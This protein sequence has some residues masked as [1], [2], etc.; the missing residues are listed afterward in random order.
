[1]EFVALDQTWSGPVHGGFRARHRFMDLTAP[2]PRAVLNET[3]E[4]KVYGGTAGPTPFWVF[5]LVSTQECATSSPLKLPEYRYGGIGFR[6]HGQWDGKANAFYLTS[7]GETDRVKAH[8]SR[9]RWCH[10]GGQV[11][12]R[13]TGMAM[14]GHPDNFRA[15]QPMRIHPDE[16]FLNFAP[17]QAGDMEI[18]PGRP[19]VSRYRCIVAD[20]PPDRALLD[21]LWNGYAHPPQVKVETVA[22]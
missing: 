21:R 5:D 9:A 14:L 12:G 16:P 20:G 3:W 4:V 2:T 10:I 13:R 1:V 18:T 7:E 19:Y 17:C 6:G 22:D 8:A 11:D 15:P